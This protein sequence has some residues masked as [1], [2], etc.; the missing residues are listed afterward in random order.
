MHLLRTLFWVA[1]AVAASA[2]AFANWTPISLTVWSGLLLDTYLPVAL[3]VAF[4]LGFLPYY[5]LHRATRWSLQRRLS[6][7]ERQL[8]EARNLLAPSPS[9]SEPGGALPPGA[10]PIAVPPGVL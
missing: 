6:Q 2:F 7:T 5:L 4:L 10:A 8:A 9:D 3:S 1:I